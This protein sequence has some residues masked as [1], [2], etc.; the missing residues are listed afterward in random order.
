NGEAP[1]RQTVS[2]ALRSQLCS[3]GQETVSSES[4]GAASWCTTIDRTNLG[5]CGDQSVRVAHS[6]VL[7]ALSIHL[8][9][10]GLQ[11]TAGSR[12]VVALQLRQRR[13]QLCE[14]RVL[15]TGFGGEVVDRRDEIAGLLRGAL[16]VDIEAARRLIGGSIR[17]GA[18]GRRVAHRERA[19]RRGDTRGARDGAVVG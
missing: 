7:A 19:P 1:A 2:G 9:D 18:R 3:G 17:C 5:G 13:R 14:Q 11:R 4:R 16:H 8:V 10:E 12:S 6:D 15:R